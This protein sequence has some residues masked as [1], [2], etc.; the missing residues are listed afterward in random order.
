MLKHWHPCRKWRILSVARSKRKAIQML[1]K[2]FVISSARRENKD[3]Q[4]KGNFKGFRE[5]HIEPDWLLIY[6]IY[7]N[8]LI[9]S[10]ERTG[11]HSDLF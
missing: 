5:C 11:S 10:L 6:K 4:L 2:C 1:T 9:L 3:H 7:E 8:Q